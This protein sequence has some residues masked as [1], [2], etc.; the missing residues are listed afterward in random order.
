MSE[1]PCTVE[2]ARREVIQGKLLAS[3]DDGSKVAILADEEMCRMLSQALNSYSTFMTYGKR[4][5]QHTQLANDI[6]QLR[7]EA[8]G[9]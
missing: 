6:E 7:K 8:F 1:K 3:L 9:R 2:P 4:R 5:N